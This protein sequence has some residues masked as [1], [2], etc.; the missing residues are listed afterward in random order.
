[1]DHTQFVS[2]DKTHIHL[3]ILHEISDLINRST[4]LNNILNAVVRKISDSLNYDAVSVYIWDEDKKV[5]RLKATVGLDVGHNDDISLRIDEGL[6]GLAFRTEK[7]V[8]A[9]PASKHPNY[10]YLPEIGE[11]RYES[12][13]GV[14]IV[15]HNRCVGVL[16]GQVKEKRLINPAEETLF[17]IVAS[18]LAGLLEV[19]DTLKRLKTSS[20]VEERMKTRQGTGVSS[21]IATGEA[22]VLRGLFQQIKPE[23]KK[24]ASVEE[25]KKR[26]I[27]AFSRVEEDLAKLI[28]DLDSKKILSPGEIDIFKAHLMIIKAPPLK[29]SFLDLI[30]K[31]NLSAE[32]AV[33]E[34]I[35]KIASQFDS[36]SDRYLK[37]KANDFRDIGERLLRELVDRREDENDSYN[38]GNGNELVIVAKEIG[39]SFIETL[40]KRKVVAIVTEKGG[41]TSH[42]VIIAK[43]LQ[44]PAVVGVE[45]VC[46]IIEQGDKIIVD[47]RT[48]FIFI[49]PSEDLISEYEKVR[50]QSV[51]LLNSLRD[52]TLGRSSMEKLGVSITANVALPIDMD[53]AKNYGIKDAGLFRTEFAFSQFARWPG[54]RE[55]LQ[56]YKRVSEQFEGY[57]TVRTMDIGADKILSYLDIPREENPLLG[58]RAIRF[59][60]ENLNLFKDQIKAILLG[61][62]KGYKLRVLLPM[63]TNIWEIETARQVMKDLSLEIGVSEQDVPPLGI[64]IEVPAIVYQIGDLSGLVEF[65]SVGTNDLIQYLLAVDRNSNIVGHLYS[66]F[67]P[68]VVRVL[69]DISEQAKGV[70]KETSVC[71]EMA[72]TPSGVL[73]LLSLGYKVL[74]VAP[75]KAPLIRYIINRVDEQRLEDL[76]IQLLSLR[77]E[78]EIR[79]V[80][81]ETL[82]SV[83]PSLI[84]IECV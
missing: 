27:E 61:V 33:I 79:N 50:T 54:V 82:K 74:S 81:Y 52:E 20:S 62:K 44:I 26:L 43:S 39:P 73:I 67:H 64:M 9:M 84:E 10:K 22:F 66:A 56:I 80:V 48:G 83:D 25:E 18:K 75:V 72:A 23:K 38:D 46:D 70:I 11:E 36:L 69:H 29:E 12:Y 40:N 77:K 49:N 68:S 42:A 51:Q 55:Q 59:S 57:V 1:M 21:G 5:L 3:K 28:N 24:I 34:G 13:I 53:M 63:V 60:M 31:K 8:V 35:E 2:A 76:K 19:A 58:L 32:F 4:G 65:I 17:Q 71:G 30:E 45:N 16:V 47:G 37:E 7:P 14:P 41:A 6:T 78:L 15:L